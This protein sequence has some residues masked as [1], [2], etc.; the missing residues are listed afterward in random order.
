MLPLDPRSY[1]HGFTG[2]E[3]ADHFGVKATATPPP[4]TV[5]VTTPPTR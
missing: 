4:A 3:L 1:T 2:T 5:S